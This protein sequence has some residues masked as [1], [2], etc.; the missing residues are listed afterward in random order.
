MPFRLAL[1]GLNAASADLNVTANNIA[2]ANTTGFK[3]SRAEFADVFSVGSQGV[4]STAV[5]NGVRLSK[6]AQQFAQGNINFTDNN[7]DLALS[8]EGFFTLSNNGSLSYSRSGAFGVDRAG[9][10]VNAQGGRLQ[11]FPP[12]GNGTFATGSLNDLRL[13][14]ADSA[15]QA[16]SR[17]ELG[18]N[19]PADA[20]VPATGTFDPADPTSYNQTT[21]TTVYDS[22]GAEHTAS[23]YF[24]K[25]AAPNTWQAHVY[26]DGNA[27]GGAN[28]MTFDSTG[29]LQTPAGGDIT[30]PGYATGTGANN[31]NLTLNT[32][33]MTQ[34][35]SD[36]GVSKLTQDGYTSGRLTGIDIDGKGIVQ[37]RFTN[38]QSKPLGQI[39]LANFSNPQGLQQQGDTSWAETY[40]SGSAIRGAAGSAS[41]GMVQSG[42]LEGSNVDLTGQLVNM[43][44]AQRNFQANAQMI[45]TADAVTQTIINIR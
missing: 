17:V 45:S 13:D 23:V 22:L 20:T 1:S 37:A 35:G 43:I 15:P 26:V 12:A 36:F 39:A 2:N 6:V 28:T 19:L 14:T 25:D 21:S 32:S 11:V 29:N 38:G 27:V 8:G 24:V 7:L 3:G 30:L 16:T 41:F 44:T 9:Y 34:F 33:D 10:V 5:G 40:S 4:S 42:A 31:I 18:A